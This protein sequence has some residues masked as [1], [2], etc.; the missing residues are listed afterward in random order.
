[1]LEPNDSK[2]AAF[3]ALALL[4]AACESKEP[5]RPRPVEPDPITSGGPSAASALPPVTG[6]ASVYGLTM[7]RLDGSPVALSSFG[8]KVVLVVNTASE[9][10]YTP[11]YEGLE[12][13]HEKYE[14]K[15]FA[16]LGFPSNDFGGQEPGSPSD[17]AAFC[18]KTYGV[19]FPM[20]DKVATVGGDRSELYT[21][22]SNALG[23]PEW[24]FH[25]YL[26]DRRGVPVRAFPSAVKPSAPDLA[27]AIE[28]QLA[29]P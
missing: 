1:M 25:K 6:A 9:C 7:K 29:T 16:V 2:V 28:Q 5:P 22:L 14:S 8:G 17:I 27:R 4:I 12:A 10:G 13:L 18:K 23:A 15:G 19:T 20:F 26:I 11:Q 24:N 21:L 3:A